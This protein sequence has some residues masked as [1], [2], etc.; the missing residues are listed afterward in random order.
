MGL[1][2]YIEKRKI[3]STQEPNQIAYF[4]KVNFLIKYFDYSENCTY[5]SISK[6]E[7]V[8]LLDR[9]QEV[10]VNHSLANEL[11]PCT[12]GFFFGSYEYDEDYFQKV[13]LVKETF[14]R[15]IEEVNFNDEELL[16]YC[17]W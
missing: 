3:G 10:L 11:L 2:I 6:A 17:W 9:C 7:V 16:I 12:E 13:K 14:T 1:D 5:Q 15:I 8:E 4:R